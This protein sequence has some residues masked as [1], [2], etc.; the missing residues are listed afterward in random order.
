MCDKELNPINQNLKII[1]KILYKYREFDKN[2]FG[3]SMA[4]N[5]DV[6]FSSANNLNDPHEGFYR[7]KSQ[8]FELDGSDLIQFINKKT[9]HFYPNAIY[10][11]KLVLRE[12]AIKQ[13]KNIQNNDPKGFEGLINLRDKKYGIFSLSSILDSIPMLFDEFQN[14][15]LKYEF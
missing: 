2:N 10:E 1:P 12:I 3:L 5:G 15:K 7:P 11:Q 8:M 14:F 6:F 13:I 9:D 4:L